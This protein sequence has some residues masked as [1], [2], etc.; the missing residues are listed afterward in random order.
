M[1]RT[2][3]QS[4]GVAALL[5]VGL[6]SPGG[7]GELP[8]KENEKIEALIKHVEGLKGAVFVRNDKEYDASVA[9]RF[10]RGKWDANKAE[11]KTAKDFIDKVATESGT[12]G[13]PYLIRYK[14]GTEKKSGEYLISVLKKL[15][16]E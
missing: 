4:L 11:I 9:A 3:L 8:A 16:S 12:T 1:R 7:A 10:L 2:L 15:N 6:S 14:D 13:K 5:L